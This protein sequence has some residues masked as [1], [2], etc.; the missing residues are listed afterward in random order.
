M[1]HKIQSVTIAPGYIKANQEEIKTGKSTSNTIA[2]YGV[3]GLLCGGVALYINSRD[4]RS[5]KR[6]NIDIQ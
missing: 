6:I 4:V 1:K 3:A 5:Q 2:M